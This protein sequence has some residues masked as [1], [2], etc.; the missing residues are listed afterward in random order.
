MGKVKYR[1]R[2]SDKKLKSY[3][4]SIGAVLI[5][6]P[7]WCGKT[8][9]AEQVAGSVLYMQDPAGMEQNKVLADTAP[10]LLLEGKT[11][12]LIDEWQLAPKLWDAVRFEVDQRRAFGQ[13]ILTGSVVPPDL[14]EISHSGTGRIARMRMRTMSL[15]ESGDS[16][17]LVSLGALFSG[18]DKIAAKGNNNI[19]DLA[20]W[21]CRGGWPM[22][23]AARDDEARLRQAYYYYDAVVSTDISQVDHVRRNE[24]SARRLMRAYAR[25]IG[26][27]T[28]YAKLLEDVTANE[29]ESFGRDVLYSYIK[30]LQE[31]FVIEDVPAWNPNLRSRTA[32]RTGDTRY[33]TDPSIAVAALGLEPD[34]LLKDLKTM[35]FLFE[36]LCIRDLKIYSEALGG[37]VYH[38]RARSGMECDAV[39]VLGDGRYGLA[40]IKLGGEQLIEEGA[41]S[42]KKL[43]A[44]IDTDHMPAPSF[45]MVVTGFGPYAYKRNDGVLV[46]PVSCL[47]D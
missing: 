9:S 43:Q 34:G 2:I 4:N 15:Y 32:I 12:R 44:Q 10:Q 13:F 45:L 3:L 16:N 39:I 18:K 14:S 46:A 1:K 27:G 33:F 31:L 42:L 47:K 24:E 23:L 22:V 28:S 5:E 30:A 19:H 11:P 37:K 36:N 17:G 25:S 7:K 8:T 26:T 38:F 20:F 21:I 35:G 40:E 6:G 41:K 29:G